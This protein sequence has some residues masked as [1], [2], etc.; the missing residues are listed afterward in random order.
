MTKEIKVKEDVFRIA[1]IAT[2]CCN[3]G[4][5]LVPKAWA[6][7]RVFAILKEEYD[8]VRQ[9]EEKTHAQPIAV[10]AAGLFSG[11][12]KNGRWCSITLLLLL[13]ETSTLLLRRFIRKGKWDKYNAV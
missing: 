6:G 7:K 10:F 12:K 8:K 9:K 2:P 5:I 1:A 13:T 4:Y 11:G 3:A